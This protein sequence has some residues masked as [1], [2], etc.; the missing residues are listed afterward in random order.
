M[1]TSNLSAQ[2]NSAIADTLNVTIDDWQ[3]AQVKHHIQQ[4]AIQI[5]QNNIDL[6]HN[7]VK[8]HCSPGGW[9]IVAIVLAQDENDK[10]AE[11]FTAD[12][13]KWKKDKSEVSYYNDAETD[14]QEEIRDRTEEAILDE[15]VPEIPFTRDMLDLS[16]VTI[17]DQFADRAT[18]E[19]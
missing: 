7:V 8:V 10:M 5:A 6:P 9:D 2:G 19:I 18:F 17:R 15:I 11:L 12:D 14:V 3:G 13:W 4:Q 1:E 16:H